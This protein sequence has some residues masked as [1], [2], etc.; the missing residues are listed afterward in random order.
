MST[1]AP[2]TDATGQFPNT[3][4]SVVLAA[5]SSPSPDSEVA[6]ARICESYWYPLYAY[7]R[8]C[9]HSVDDA[10]DLTQGFFCRLLGKRWLDRAD[11]TRGRL[12]T[13]LIVALKNFMRSEWRHASALRRGGGRAPVPIDT[14]FAET[15]LAADRQALAP[16]ET[17]D[18]QWAI[19]LLEIT[20]ARLR[21]ESGTTGKLPDFEI[22]K[23][24]LMADRGAIDYAA[25]A[26][27]LGTSEGAVRV[28]VHRLRKRFREVFREEISRTLSED[29][30]LEEEIRHLVAALTKR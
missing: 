9:G 11:R 6:L 24:C 19:T 3:R 27:Q 14:A 8:R 29:A 25:M 2:S 30:N 13:Y 15:R 18:R 1:R 21:E 7:A 20:T 26:A 23:P 22:L 17:F 28:A 5:Q 4:W 10:Q 12:R 16:D